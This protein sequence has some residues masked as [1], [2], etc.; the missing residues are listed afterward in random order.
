MA[1]NPGGPFSKSVQALFDDSQSDLFVSAASI[2]EIAIKFAIGKIDLKP[3]LL[4]AAL[5]DLRLN[6]IP[7]SKDHAFRLYS[8]PKYHRDPFDRMILA[9]A[10]TEDL[11]IITGDRLFKRYKGVRTI[12]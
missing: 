12:W 4:Q 5:R 1:A 8:L 6:V 7:I 9:T 11:P 10:L 3:E 2:V